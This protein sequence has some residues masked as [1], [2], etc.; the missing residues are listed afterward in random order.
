MINEQILISLTDILS[1]APND[2]Y[3]AVYINSSNNTGNGKNLSKR[4]VRKS[5]LLAAILLKTNGVNNPLQTVLDL[6][7]GS[8]ITL[9]P[10]G[11]GGVTIASSGGGG[12]ILTADN[13]LTLNTAT[14]VQLGGT[15]IQNTVITQ[16]AY[17][18]TFNQNNFG[19]PSIQITQSGTYGIGLRSDVVD[20]SAIYG[21]T[22][23]GYG[24]VG[25]SSANGIGGNFSSVTNY[26]LVART[27]SGIAA[28]HGVAQGDTYAA[29][30]QRQVNGN[31][32]VI[33]GVLKIRRNQIG[34]GDV[35]L[36]GYGA[37]I[38]FY[39]GYNG[40]AVGETLASVISTLWT[41]P[42]FASRTSQFRIE[43]FSNGVQQTVFEVKGNGQGVL[44]KYGIGTFAA[45]AVYLLGVDA[46]GNVVE[47][48]ASGTGTVT[49]VA[50]TVPSPSNPAFS[51]SV[52]NPT[53]T[54]SVDIVALGNA[55]QYIAGDGSLATLPTNVSNAYIFSSNNSDIATYEQ[56][57]LLSLYVPNALASIITS[58]STSPTLLANFATNLNYPNTT[59]IPSGIATVHFET[60]KN[61]GS[62]DYQ[63]YA[64]IY[65]RSSGGTETLL[66][67]SDLTTLVSTNSVIQQFVTFIFATNTTILTTDRIVVKIYAQMIS[68]VN[69]N[70][71]LFYDATTNSRLELPSVGVNISGLV[72]YT[73]ATADVDLGL[74]GLTADTIDIT[75]LAAQTTPA[76]NIVTQEGTTLKYRTPAQILIDSGAYGS[77]IWNA[78]RF[79]TASNSLNVLYVAS[80]NKLYVP[81]LSSNS[82]TIF[83]VSTGEILATIAVTNAYKVMLITLPSEEVWVSSTSLTTLTRISV[84]TNASLGTITG[85]SLSG[86]EAVTYSATDVFM[87]CFLASGVI[88]RINPTTNTVTAS[89]TTS[90]PSFCGGMA[91]NTNGS[92]LQNGKII[93][94]GGGGTPG[95]AIFNPATSTIS[96][97]AANPGGAINTGRRI[98][99]VPST[100]QYI[101]SSSANN[102]GVIFSIATA[103][104]FSVSQ[105]LRN[106]AIPHD[107]VV[108]ETNGYYFISCLDGNLSGM[109]INMFSLSTNALLN[110][111]YNTSGTN[112]SATETSMSLDIPNKRIFGLGRRVGT[113]SCVV[114]KY[115]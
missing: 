90:V 92:S 8:N 15:L 108:D 23:N 57:V 67:T 43:L 48:T 7:A 103:T 13:G 93:I 69:R 63:C 81:N 45:T 107:V 14:N 1:S 27:T 70:I 47:T 16:N 68:G 113:N 32:S 2:A 64:E 89:I 22:T 59:V 86:Y 40:G 88:M 58:V 3:V 28:I 9:T 104:T 36:S 84:T 82:V 110:S 38:D 72:P 109:I 20:G 91:Y 105:T 19:S 31:L 51:V 6:K 41:D 76:T 79:I 99:Y 96:T 83:N 18:L 80:Q 106:I 98:A 74:F 65:K 54:P 100:D 24:I 30:L 35:P 102:V 55:T 39:L 52:P 37:S 50:A 33:T 78:D 115:L 97:A 94:T 53:T 49:S 112:A 4:Y 26:G 10:D 101:V 66:Q 44:N 75:S 61:L 34:A 17:T 111:F 85:V 62:I 95:L 114:T 71:T 87:T 60:Q 12:G 46:S 29:H 21:T 73:G 5:T 25:V 42:I 11:L 56:M 77:I